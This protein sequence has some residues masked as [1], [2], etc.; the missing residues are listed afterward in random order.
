M[1][2]Q[3]S[4]DRDDKTQSATTGPGSTKDPNQANRTPQPKKEPIKPDVT[5]DPN[6]ENPATGPGSTRD[7]NQANRT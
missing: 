2:N 1:S 7:P 5:P 4:D 6:P 3:D